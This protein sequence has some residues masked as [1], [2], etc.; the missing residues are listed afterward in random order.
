MG[1]IQNNNIYNDINNFNNNS[2]IS[3][4]MDKSSGFQKFSFNLNL[5]N[6]EESSKN[7]NHMLNQ[8]KIFYNKLDIK[9]L[10]SILA[11]KIEKEINLKLL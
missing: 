2:N 7:L 3:S 6:D 10:I 5:L 4:I 11:S 1:D 8:T 9:S